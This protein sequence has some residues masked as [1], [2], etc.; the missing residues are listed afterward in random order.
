MAKTLICSECGGS[1]MVQRAVFDEVNQ[2]V[3]RRRKCDNC[4]RVVFSIEYEIETTDKVEQL[5]KNLNGWSM[6][7]K[8]RQYSRDYYHKNRE[9]LNAYKA[10]YN[11]KKKAAK[12]KKD[13]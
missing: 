2:E 9:R 13:D 4:G 5:W 7:E 1:L 12:E 8:K 3:Y 11:R 10:E 6:S